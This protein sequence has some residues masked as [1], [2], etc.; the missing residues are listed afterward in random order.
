MSQK[1]D[2]E[3]IIFAYEKGHIYIVKILLSNPNVDPSDFNNFSLTLA[4]KNGNIDVV[5]L[6]I[7]DKRIDPA[8]LENA[9]IQLAFQNDHIDIVNLLIGNERVKSTLKKDLLELYSKQ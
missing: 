9:P 5:S 1:T 7:K 6:L 2:D 4:A 8:C 3:F